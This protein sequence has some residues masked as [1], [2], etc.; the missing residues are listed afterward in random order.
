MCNGEI[1]ERENEKRISPVVDV[2]VSSLQKYNRAHH[3]MFIN[4]LQSASNNN[5]RYPF[6]GDINFCHMFQ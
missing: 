6:F 5:N 2:C 1:V 4:V 3:P